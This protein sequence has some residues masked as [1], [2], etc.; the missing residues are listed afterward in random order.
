ML[1][2][3]PRLELKDEPSPFQNWE[4]RSQF[5]LMIMAIYNSMEM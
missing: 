5:R 1:V 4:A 2:N 3:V